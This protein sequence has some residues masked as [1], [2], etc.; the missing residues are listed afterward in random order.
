MRKLLHKGH[1]V[2]MR[3]IDTLVISPDWNIIIPCSTELR[4]K[5]PRY[6]DI[7]VQAFSKAESKTLKRFWNLFDSRS[8]QSYKR[9]ILVEK[10]RKLNGGL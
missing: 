5:L 8:D 3:R 7:P 2:G 4:P 10:P 1:P 6:D 9:I